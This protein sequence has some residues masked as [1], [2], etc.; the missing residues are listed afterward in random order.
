[1][2]RLISLAVL[3]VFV[4]Q[5]RVRAEVKLPSI[6]TDN[7]VIQQVVDMPLWGTAAAGERVVVSIGDNSAEATADAEGR[8]SCKL[9]PMVASN[10]PVEMTVRGSNTIILKNIL[11]GEMWFCAGQSNM[12][13]TLSRSQDGAAEI[14]KA[15]HPSI[16]LFLR[17]ENERWVA[18]SPKNI[19]QYS[20][21]AYYFGRHLH[22]ELDRP[23][24][25]IT[26]GVEGSYIEEWI[27]RQTYASDPT[28]AEFPAMIES[29]SPASRREIHRRVPTARG[30]AICE[31]DRFS[32]F[33]IRYRP[34]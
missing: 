9:K 7:M 11:V 6:F 20:A 4:V 28:L 12:G 32:S 17:G 33:D 5:L 34:A 16:R 19:A 25:L 23:I 14:E 15:N 24:G 3:L 2:L 29:E 1:M 30:N 27:S 31:I 18:C 8:W 10:V 13:W 22:R 21:V 26:A